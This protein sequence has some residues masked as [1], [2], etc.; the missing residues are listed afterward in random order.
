MSPPRKVALRQR[1]RQKGHA[2]ESA[3]TPRIPSDYTV[4][5]ADTAWLAGWPGVRVESHAYTGYFVRQIS[6]MLGKG[7]ATA[8]RTSDG[9]CA[10]DVRMV[11]EAS[12][13]NR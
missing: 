13:H 6:S 8:T 4:A 12:D 1:T 5:G 2:I 9:L 10:C 3:S 7:I 11:V